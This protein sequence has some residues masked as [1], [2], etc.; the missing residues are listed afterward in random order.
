[1]KRA[2]IFLG[3]F[4]G[5]MCPILVSTRIQKIWKIIVPQQNEEARDD[6]CTCDWCRCSH[7]TCTNLSRIGHLLGNTRN[8]DS[9]H[10]R[11]VY[12]HHRPSIRLCSFTGNA[13]HAMIVVKKYR[14]EC[15]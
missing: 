5:L 12:P 11:T 10:F 13:P 2:P 8:L 15:F 7:E 1:M 6:W 4:L 14:R 3:L 9:E